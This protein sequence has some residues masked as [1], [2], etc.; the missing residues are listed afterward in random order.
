[1]CLQIFQRMVP[2]INSLVD[3]TVITGIV[4]DL[5]NNCHPIATAAKFLANGMLLCGIGFTLAGLFVCACW[6]K[7]NKPSGTVSP[8]DDLK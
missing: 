2:K 7:L 3:C 6:R 5:A 4:V 1:V 8:Y